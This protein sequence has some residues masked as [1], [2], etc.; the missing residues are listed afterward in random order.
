MAED[1][2]FEKVGDFLGRK[3][4]NLRDRLTFDETDL[5]RA[6]GKNMNS[7]VDRVLAAGVDP[8]IAD[9]IGRR[10]LVMAVDNNNV[11][12]AQMLLGAGADPNLSGKDTLALTKAVFWE[13]EELILALLEAGADEEQ[14]GPDGKTAMEEARSTGVERL[15]SLIRDFEARRKEKSIKKDKELHQRQKAQA[16]KAKDNREKVEARLQE[17]AQEKAKS[18]TLSRYPSS[19]KD[20]LLALVQAIH[21]QDEDAIALL[22]LQVENLNAFEPHTKTTPLLEAIKSKNAFATGLLL[23]RGADP[24]VEVEG[25]NYSGFSQAVRQKAYGL[26]SKILEG[27]TEEAKEAMNDPKQD[28]SP[29]FMA[30][31]DP[32]LFNLLLKGGADPFWGGSEGQS[33]VIKAIAKGSIGILPVLSRHQVDLNAVIDDKSVI[34]WAIFYN[35]KDWVEGLLAEGVTKQDDLVEYTRKLG[36]R[37]EIA[38]YLSK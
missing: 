21:E 4:R 30:Y 22:I 18:E 7:E 32:R 16:Q 3:A 24:L 6:V 19:T 31:K 27:R 34:Q 28:I 8:N 9:I 2:F 13:N 37:D 10:P 1:D 38:D 26:V 20:P 35:R 36:G 17:E 5:I 11:E 25:T 12:I 29:Q 33:P 14:A 23:E 15:I